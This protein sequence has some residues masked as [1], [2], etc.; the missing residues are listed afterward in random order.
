MEFLPEGDNQLLCKS[1]KELTWDNDGS[2][3]YFYDNFLFVA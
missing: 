2:D 3:K 1:E